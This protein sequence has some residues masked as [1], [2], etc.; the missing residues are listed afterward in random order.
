MVDT[1]CVVR[2]SCGIDVMSRFAWSPSGYAACGAGF[3]CES[4]SR[5]MVDRAH[6]GAK[7][8]HHHLGVCAAWLQIPS[9]SRFWL[10]SVSEDLAN[11]VFRM[12]VH[13]YSW[14]SAG[15][16]PAKI[17]KVPSYSMIIMII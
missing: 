16:Q 9:D 4:E 11:R 13:G 1:L 2:M 6:A 12:G 7:A 10:I 5:A 14:V 8:L 17:H 3:G 15:E